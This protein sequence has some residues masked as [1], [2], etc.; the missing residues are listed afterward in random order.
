MLKRYGR[1]YMK[2]QR[3]TYHGDYRDLILV[4]KF[5][6]IDILVYLPNYS[7]IICRPYGITIAPY[8]L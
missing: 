3:I 7:I 2:N 5:I 8:N 4:A 6:S 1:V